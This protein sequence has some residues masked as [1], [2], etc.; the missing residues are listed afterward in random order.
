MGVIIH[1]PKVPG[2]LGLI[3]LR[4]EGPNREGANHLLRFAHPRRETCSTWTGLCNQQCYLRWRASRNGLRAV[5]AG[6]KI[7]PLLCARIRSS[8]GVRCS[9]RRDVHLVT[10]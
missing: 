1:Y 7:V 6:C 10:G 3:H 9:P 8:G 4:G 2:I 5:C